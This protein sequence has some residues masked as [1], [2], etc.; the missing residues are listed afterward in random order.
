M[1]EAFA[2]I[3]EELKRERAAK[4]DLLAALHG[5]VGVIKSWHNMGVVEGSELD[6]WPIYYAHSPEM[7]PIRDALAKATS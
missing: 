6:V 7:K 2:N 5:A 4:D 3:R 1:M